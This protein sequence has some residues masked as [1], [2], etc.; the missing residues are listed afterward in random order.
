MAR[1]HANCG[2]G[3]GCLYSF[4]FL[5]NTNVEDRR[6]RL[7]DS[8]LKLTARD[9]ILYSSEKVSGVLVEHTVCFQGTSVKRRSEII[10]AGRG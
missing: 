4:L 8:P 2:G 7:V 9:K 6:D 10:S 3:V 5:W 1:N